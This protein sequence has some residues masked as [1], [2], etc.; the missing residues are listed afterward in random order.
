MCCL[1]LNWRLYIRS[2]P[3][4]LQTSPGS[5]IKKGFVFSIV[6][7]TTRSSRPCFDS[8]ELLSCTASNEFLTADETEVALSSICTLVGHQNVVGCLPDAVPASPWRA[9]Q[10]SGLVAGPSF[11]RGKLTLPICRPSDATLLTIFIQGVVAC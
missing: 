2:I 3:H 8:L 5:I 6:S 11:Q 7:K 10:H 9:D 4:T 1:P